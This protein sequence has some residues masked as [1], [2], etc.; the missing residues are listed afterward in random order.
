MKQHKG[1]DDL[2]KF[3]PIEK[4]QKIIL[5]TIKNESI[6]DELAYTQDKRL[7]QMFQRSPI[8]ELREEYYYLQYVNRHAKTTF[9][10]SIESLA[11]RIF[12]FYSQQRTFLNL[13]SGLGHMLW[14]ASDEY[15]FLYGEEIDENIAKI[16]E[17]LL[18]SSNNDSKIKIQVVDSTLNLKN[19][20]KF[21]CVYCNILFPN[22]DSEY[23]MEDEKIESEG[24]FETKS[25]S[26]EW[27]FVNR[28]LDS[29]EDTGTGI[30]IM[31][32]TSI[33]LEM[34][35][36]I[37]KSL[38]EKGLIK[39]VIQL[40][41]NIAMTNKP[42][43]LLVL[44]K[45]GNN[46]ITFIDASKIYTQKGRKQKIFE[47]KDIKEIMKALEN[48]SLISKKVNSQTIIN[49]DYNLSP[50][51]YLVDIKDYLGKPYL[52]NRCCRD[53]PRERCF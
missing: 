47:D 15:S 29:L 42:T 27:K 17:Q 1:I 46:K 21:E 45:C 25:N 41:S 10:E 11:L 16:S 24:Y 9:N 32:K 3:V 14:K 5:R 40:P 30:I 33:T 19:K 52:L 34:S 43:I 31:R 23:S 44:Q 6:N 51:H 18:N 53:Y 50:I 2:R 22:I 12:K 48:E 36:D 7:M 49:N 13:G 28:I 4:I 26:L 8:N 38:V 20:D 35:K 37:R 39:A